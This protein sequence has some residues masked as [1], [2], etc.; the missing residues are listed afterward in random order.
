MGYR[1][2]Y[3]RYR[4]RTRPPQKKEHALGSWAN[5]YPA[6]PFDPANIDKITVYHSQAR[7]RGTTEMI[8]YRKDNLPQ[9]YRNDYGDY[10]Q[11][12]RWEPHHEQYLQRFNENKLERIN[13]K[14]FKS[15]IPKAS[16]EQ[17]KENYVLFERF[18]R[19][20]D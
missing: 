8:A 17:I 3:Y 19:Y 18:S 20:T 11:E 6:G 5:P 13:G 14:L 7:Y 10:L 9:E 16:F 1:R 12:L 2:N 15:A 4:S